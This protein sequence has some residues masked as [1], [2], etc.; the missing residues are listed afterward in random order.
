MSEL[1]SQQYWVTVQDIA[2]EIEGILRTGKD[3]DGYDLSDGQSGDYPHTDAAHDYLHQRIDG[4]QYVIYTHLARQVLECSP[5]DSAIFEELGAQEWEDWSTA[6][7]Q[8]AFFAM[9][10]DV[11]E[12]VDWTLEPGDCDDSEAA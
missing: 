4:H 12:A 11:S 5:N 1:T 7:S 9:Q 8:S 2:S 3:P 6:F 10:A